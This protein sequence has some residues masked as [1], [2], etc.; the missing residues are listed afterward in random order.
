MRL[1]CMINNFLYMYMCMSVIYMYLPILLM[2][3]TFHSQQ[4]Y[5]Y[6]MNWEHFLLDKNT[7]RLTSWFVL[8]RCDCQKCAHTGCGKQHDHILI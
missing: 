4:E 8:C 7:T 6:M 5:V 3:S 2:G 1:D